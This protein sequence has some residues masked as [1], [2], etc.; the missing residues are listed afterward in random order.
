MLL[1]P[2][3]APAV[4]LRLLCASLAASTAAAGL[5]TVRND[6]PR[7][8]QFGHILNAHDGSVV[9]I[10]GVYFMYGT[11]YENCTQRGSQCDAPCGYSPN[12]FSLYTSPDLEAWTFISADILPEMKKD[13]AQVDYWMPVVARN[14]KTQMFVMQYWS[15]RCGFS[16]PCA[17]VATAESPYGPFTMVPPLAVSAV[18]SSQ[19]GFFAD[20]ATGKGYV[21]YNTGDPQHHV[22][23]ELSDDWL[24]TTGRYAIVFWKVAFAW[25]EGGGIFKKG[26]LYYYMTGAC[27]DF[28]I[29]RRETLR[30]LRHPPPPFL[31]VSAG[32]DCCF[33]TWG[34][35]ARFWTAYDPL[36]PWH[37][38]V[39]PPLPAPGAT[40]NVTGAWFSVAGSP[41][42]PG[43][44]TLTLTQAAGSNNFTFSDAH[45]EAGGWIDQSTGYVHFPPSAGDGRG[46]ITSADGT[47]AGCDRIRWFGYD[48]FIWCRSGS[49]CATPSYRDAPEVNYCA[50][51][52]LPHEDV[53]VNPCAPD[54]TQGT[55]FTV[56]ETPSG[57]TPPLS[58]IHGDRTTAEPCSAIPVSN[59]VIGAGGG[60]TVGLKVECAV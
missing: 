32:T 12:T 56:P 10:D 52:S 55:N 46:V 16:K 35:D 43:N 33:C 45:G 58:F 28:C 7:V 14:P 2:V 21:R 30:C 26:S 1:Q 4:A 13:N 37:P 53:R 25:M 31:W 34:G 59:S 54:N 42:A 9:Y 8:D 50:D 48:S 11:V 38:G 20:A 3:R 47:A 23:E 39:A 49:A 17:D 19:M 18:P 27:G 40:C 41:D 29:A 6:V 57:T 44:E 51:G 5:V 15:G 24:S 22:V 60:T 36:G